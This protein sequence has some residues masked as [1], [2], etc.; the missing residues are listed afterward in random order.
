MKKLTLTICLT[1]LS[2]AA[3][4]EPIAY[5]KNEAGGQIIFTNETC[6]LRGEPYPELQRVFSFTRSGNTIEG[7]YYYE[8][9]SQLVMVVWADNGKR[10]VFPLRNIT[11][12]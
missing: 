4:A 6:K 5:I 11:P 3:S 7:C 8:A 9:R 2:L 10:S 1:L 12:F